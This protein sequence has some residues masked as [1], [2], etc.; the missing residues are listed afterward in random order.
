MENKKFNFTKEAIEALPVPPKGKRAYYRDEKQAGLILDVKPSGSKSFY[1]YK[2][3]DGKPERIFLGTFPDTKVAK[4]RKL[5]EIKRGEIADGKNPQEE[6][7]KI[8]A[9]ITFGEFFQDYL[10]RYS[11]LQKRSWQYDE[12]EV[13]RFLL[14]WFKRKLSSIKKYEVQKLQEEIF[15]NNGL[16]QANRILERIRAIYNKAIEW[17]WEGENPA[18]GIKKYKEKSRDRFIQPHELPFLFRALEIEEN[19]TASDYLLIS[20]MTGA[21]K[22][23]VLS[24]RW[25]EIDWQRMEWRIPETKN[26]EPVTIPLIEQAMEI[27]ERRKRRARNGYVFEG[28]GAS[29]HLADPKRTW[30]RVRQRATLEVWK[31]FPESAKLIEETEKK[32]QEADNYGY[33]ILKLFNT[34][35]KEAEEQEIELPQ[36]LMDLRIHDIRRTLGSYQA[37]TGASL[38]I[39]GKTLGHK[40][41]QSTAVYARLHSDPVREAMEKANAAMF[42]FAKPN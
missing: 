29:G 1:L 35:Q 20:L 25:E 31:L 11:K 22:A 6:K 15:R 3:I 39:I 23:N 2:K 9:E 7:R 42:G 33:T 17:G 37:I 36:G 30:D 34:V 14:H 16:Y 8:R 24:M 40:S 38:P 27:L 21:R 5:A 41:H 28:E 13:N 19:E 26:G 4:A 10:E 18:K 12:R 32:L